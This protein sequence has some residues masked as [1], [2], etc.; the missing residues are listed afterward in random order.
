MAEN[1]ETGSAVQETEQNSPG[2]MGQ[3]HIGDIEAA[4]KVIDYASDQG[5]FKG[6]P[7]INDVLA[8]RNRLV[9]FLQQ[10]TP[11]NVAT[12]VPPDTAETPV[13]PTTEGSN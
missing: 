4:V 11:V 9:L 1:T 8:I 13:A 12:D 5:A 10:V 6:W 7:V 2:P 3:L